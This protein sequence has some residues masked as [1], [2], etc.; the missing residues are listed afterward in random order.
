MAKRKLGSIEFYKD[1]ELIG[2]M[3]NLSDLELDYMIHSAFNFGWLYNKTW[4]KGKQKL[5]LSLTESEG[6]QTRSRQRTK[7]HKELGSIPQ[8]SIIPISSQDKE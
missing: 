1:N 5:T 6:T 4:Q 8:D 2:K 3:V 7:R